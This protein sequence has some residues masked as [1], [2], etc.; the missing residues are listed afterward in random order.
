M[1]CR[2]ALSD[3]ACLTRYPF[4]HFRAGYGFVFCEL[5][6]FWRAE[7]MVSCV[8]DNAATCQFI[9]T[10]YVFLVKFPLFCDPPPPCLCPQDLS[11]YLL[12]AAW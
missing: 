10:E 5:C 4:D 3:D 11:R 7:S 8:V 2:P 6:S 1:Y 12:A 9:Y